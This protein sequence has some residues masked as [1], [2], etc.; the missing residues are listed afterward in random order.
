VANDAIDL[1]RTLSH[2]LRHEPWLYEIEL[3]DEGWVSVESVLAALRKE[4]PEWTDLSATDLV[5]MIESSSKR[6]H[7]I[8]SGRIRALYGHS[9]AGKLKRTPA[10]P[11][12][13]L[14]HGTAP[15]VVAAIKASGLL[16]M[17]RQNVHLSIDEAT[18]AE[19]GRRKSK[20]P[21]ILRVLAA[22]A[23]GR[24]I[25]FYEGNDK[26]WLADFVPSE[27]VEEY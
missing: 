10:I 21:V 18:A 2:A 1:S 25:R 19:V 9:I 20:K 7:E 24:G 14:Y 22:A 5:H 17:G 27:F 16:S 8:Q 4:K 23:H 13:V 12:N 11:P 6:R 3:D 15:D 26:V